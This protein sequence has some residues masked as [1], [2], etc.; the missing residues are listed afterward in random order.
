[1]L[2]LAMLLWHVYGAN[3]RSTYVLGRGRRQIKSSPPTEKNNI[4]IGQQSIARAL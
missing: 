3:F 4:E 2:P 1:M